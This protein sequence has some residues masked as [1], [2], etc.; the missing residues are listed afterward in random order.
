M[1]RVRFATAAVMLWAL[2]AS[3]AAAQGRQMGGVGITVYD[4]PNFRGRNATFR[5]A[6]VNLQRSG[7]NDRISSLEVA[8]GEVWEACEHDNFRGRCQVFSGSENN[9]RQRGWNDMISSLRPIRGG[10][11]YPPYPT[12]PTYP[13]VRPP[14]GPGPGYPP[15]GLVL[16]TGVNF[17]GGQQVFT[18]GVPDLR[19]MN[20]DNRAAS[21]RLPPGQVW[22]VCR[23]RNY[24]NC[25]QVNTDWATLRQLNMA[26]QISS[27]RPRP[28]LGGGG[29]W[30][31]Q[32]LPGRPPYPG[33]NVGRA[34]LYDGRNFSGQSFIATGVHGNL[35]RFGGRA[36]SLQVQGGVWELC[37]GTNFTGRCVTFNQNANDL[38]QYGFHNR[39]RSVR[40]LPGGVY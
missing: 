20:F 36:E 32:P 35:G 8:P 25:L 18:T 26:G 7:M 34:V 12:N 5:T 15:Q 1:R 27:L 38:R 37:D 39:I 14:I 24:R 19:R 23:D 11:V 6:I 40:P 31:Q 17:S 21:L 28:D 30:P 9:L 3:M 4:D 10:S 16:Y 2:M 22:E 33:Q 29:G 13:P